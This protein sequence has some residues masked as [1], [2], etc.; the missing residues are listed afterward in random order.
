MY[1]ER[2]VSVAR[3][4]RATAIRTYF[5][6]RT[7]LGPRTWNISIC[8]V[9]TFE[10]RSGSGGHESVGCVVGF[11]AQMRT[12]ME[13][14]HAQQR[15]LRDVLVGDAAEAAAT[16]QRVQRGVAAAGHKGQAMQI[17]TNK[18]PAEVRKEVAKAMQSGAALVQASIEHLDT[19]ERSWDNWINERSVV[20]KKY[21]S[22]VQVLSYMSEKSRTRQREC[23]AQRGKRRK[24]GDKVSVR[25]YVA[26]LGNNRWVHKYPALR[27]LI[28]I[29]M[30]PRAQR[31]GIP[32]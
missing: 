1:V 24:G 7:C 27:P 22:E 8:A 30:R 26:E 21:P 5:G 10:R 11:V 13:G 19:A 25:N 16:R 31:R 6:P 28:L 32:Q 18:V 9:H 23:L 29:G 3:V 14:A 17:T 12:A 4:S 20:V 15:Q 2:R